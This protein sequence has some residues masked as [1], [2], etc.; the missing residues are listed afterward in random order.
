MPTLYDPPPERTLADVG[1]IGGNPAA[2][3]IDCEQGTNAWFTAR[4]GRFTASH[5]DQVFKLDGTPKTG[6][7]RAS[8]MH[9]LIAERWT[10]TVEMGHTTAA[11]ERGTFLEPRA[12]SWYSDARAVYVREVGFVYANAERSWGV[13]PDGLCDEWGFETKALMRR[14]HV[15]VVVRNQPQPAHVAQCRACMLATGLRRWDL[16]YY[17]PEPQMPNAVFRIE[18]D[19]EVMGNVAE[20]VAAF[21]GML[22]D[23]AGNGAPDGEAVQVTDEGDVDISDGEMKGSEL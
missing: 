6:D 21:C 18:W 10:R 8:Y 2:I 20:S 9:G 23:K 1:V 14:G 15:G 19:D 3:V 16:L 22:D 7:T 4:I 5:A 12:R 11:M 17:T 13:S